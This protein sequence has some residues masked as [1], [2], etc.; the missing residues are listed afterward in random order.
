[1]VLWVLNLSEFIDFNF[2]CSSWYIFKSTLVTRATDWSFLILVLTKQITYSEWFR[3]FYIF[4]Y[5]SRS[6]YVC[7]KWLLSIIVYYYYYYCIII[8]SGNKVHIP[9][10]YVSSYV[11]KAHAISFI[12]VWIPRSRKQWHVATHRLTGLAVGTI[13]VI[14]LIINLQICIILRI[15]WYSISW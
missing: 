10:S 1:M 2:C 12:S 11:H 15:K 7:Y 4:I 13:T 9:F 5:L 3:L 14:L 6:T 8:F